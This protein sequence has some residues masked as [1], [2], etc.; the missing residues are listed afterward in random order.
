MP[1]MEGLESL[2]QI[3]NL[4]RPPKVVVYA[5]P[6]HDRDSIHVGA[7]SFLEGRSIPLVGLAERLSNIASQLFVEDCELN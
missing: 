5:I 2:Q 7:L 3:H 6:R 1:G 4:H